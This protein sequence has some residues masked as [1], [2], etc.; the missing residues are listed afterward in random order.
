MEFCLT[1]N[2]FISKDTTFGLTVTIQYL[3]IGDEE[4]MKMQR[5]HRMASEHGGL[6]Y[7]N[8]LLMFCVELF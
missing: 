1:G 2:L 5:K 3:G 4:S 8:T 6:G 7:F